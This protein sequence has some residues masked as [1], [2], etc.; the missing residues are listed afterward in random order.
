MIDKTVTIKGATDQELSLLISRLRKE[1]ELQNL[2]SD[3]KRKSQSPE[4][5]MY[6]ENWYNSFGVNTETPI[7]KL[8]H[9]LDDV[10]EHLGVLGMHWGKRKAGKSGNANK[11]P[12]MRTVDELMRTK[13]GQKVAADII[14]K[15]LDYAN[16]SKARKLGGFALR[17]VAVTATFMAGKALAQVLLS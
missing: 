14:K 10:L 7:E 17:S 12:K 4:D 15:N 9:E 3:I 1:N 8:Y 16:M 2:I 13:E 11:K 6:N 5:A